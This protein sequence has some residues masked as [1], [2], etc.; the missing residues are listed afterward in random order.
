MSSCDRHPQE[1]R[2]R[3]GGHGAAR[4]DRLGFE[5]QYRYILAHD[6]KTYD[7]PGDLLEAQS[8]INVLRSELRGL[9]KRQPWSAEPLPAWTTHENAWR[10]ASRPDSPA[11]TPRSGSVSSG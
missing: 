8:E 4:R 7:F 11:G 9:L 2:P 10:L 3:G 6:K 1:L 5:R